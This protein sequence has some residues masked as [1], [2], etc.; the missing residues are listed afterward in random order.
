VISSSCQIKI[1]TSEALPNVTI[2]GAIKLEKMLIL[3]CFNLSPHAGT[4]TQKS[5]F[6]FGYATG[7]LDSFGQV[8]FLFWLLFPQA[9]QIM[10]LTSFLKC[11]AILG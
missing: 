2:N 1:Y 10:I 3:L 5:L 8:S 4:V 9:M 7:L 11:F 6:L